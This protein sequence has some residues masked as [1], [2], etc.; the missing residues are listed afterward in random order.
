[1][2]NTHGYRSKLLMSALMSSLSSHMSNMPNRILL[3]SKYIPCIPMVQKLSV[4]TSQ[5]CQ[6]KLVGVGH[7]FA[8]QVA[9]PSRL[10]QSTSALT[11]D[12]D[13]YPWVF[14][15]WNAILGSVWVSTGW[16]GATSQK[17]V[18]SQ[19]H[20]REHLDKILQENK[21]SQVTVC[22]LKYVPNVSLQWCSLLVSR[23]P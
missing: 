1:M 15:F 13:P 17:L 4:H 16:L 9:H 18:G 5:P 11:G 19:V 3:H 8:W 20:W 2:W 21:P 7:C 22:L 6:I 23:L 10:M 12:L 14:Q